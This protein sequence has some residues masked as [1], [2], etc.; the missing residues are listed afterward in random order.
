MSIE[1]EALGRQLSFVESKI[2]LDAKVL[3]KREQLLLKNVTA[4]RE[5]QEQR[6]SMT[7]QMRHRFD[8][9]LKQQREN[10]RT[11]KACKRRIALEERKR[12]VRERQ[13]SVRKLSEARRGDVPLREIDPLYYASDDE[14]DSSVVAL[15]APATRSF[16]AVAVQTP[17]NIVLPVVTAALPSLLDANRPSVGVDPPSDY[18]MKIDE[19]RRLTHAHF[20]AIGMQITALVGGAP[21]LPPTPPSG[22]VRHEIESIIN[23]WLG[24]ST[25]QYLVKWVGCKKTTYEP[26]SAIVLDAP[27]A[28]ANFQAKQKRNDVEMKRRHDRG[29]VDERQST[30]RRTSRPSVV[31]CS[32][33]S[34]IRASSRI[35]AAVRAAAVALNSLSQETDANETDGDTVVADEAAQMDARTAVLSRGDVGPA[36]ADEFVPMDVE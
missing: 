21:T 27:T 3:A 13:R 19:R 6:A 1:A 35:R 29:D 33:V 11:I 12:A 28:V 15:H 25:P 14:A 2:A 4:E 16:V 10:N 22:D 34:I 36:S 17:M 26:M 30:R 23:E 24:G 20:A 8:L 32:S 18:Q 9:A 7:K 31:P 5:P